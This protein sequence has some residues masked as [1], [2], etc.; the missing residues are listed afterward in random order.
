[1]PYHDGPYGREKVSRLPFGGCDCMPCSG[2]RNKRRSGDVKATY[3][4]DSGHT[5]NYFG[6]Q[7]AA[8]GP[9]HG[10]IRVDE[11][12]DPSIIRD[13]YE[14]GEPFARRNAT[15]LETGG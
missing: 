8:D 11:Q 15:E 2:A 4:P 14:P 3:N 13:S 12:G 5:D 6:G 1:M 10:H 9:G 7:D